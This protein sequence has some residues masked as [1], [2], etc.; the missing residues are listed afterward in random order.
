ML[1]RRAASRLAF[2]W[3]DFLQHALQRD[4]AQ[5]EARE[6]HDG[7]LLAILGRFVRLPCRRSGEGH[8]KQQESA[9]TEER[10]RHLD[11][12]G[13]GVELAESGR[14]R[15]DGRVYCKFYRLCNTGWQHGILGIVKACTWHVCVCYVYGWGKE[16]RR[17]GGGGGGRGG[18]GWACV[19]VHE[20]V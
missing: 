11:S 8:R 16:E 15:S 7:R 6:G 1:R 13:E 18:C 5:T 12:R 2:I 20:R 19:R 10:A 3:A 9:R 14:S 4:C 17:S